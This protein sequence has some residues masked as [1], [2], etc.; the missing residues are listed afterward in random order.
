[1]S[2]FALLDAEGCVVCQ[3]IP[4]REALL[5]M[6]AVLVRRHFSHM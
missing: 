5:S 1:M 2:C 3:V 6:G 4:V